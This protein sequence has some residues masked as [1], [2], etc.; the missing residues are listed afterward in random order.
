[1]KVVIAGSR[2]ITSYGQV[3]PVVD[4]AQQ[5]FDFKITEVVSGR[6]V[7]VDRLGEVY[8]IQ[9]GIDIKEFP[10]DWDN[11]GKAAGPERN[12]RMADYADAAVFIWDGKST[13]TLHMIREMKKRR[14]PYYIDLVI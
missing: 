10:A 1:M 7:G 12:C 6:A 11:L 13:G 3:A 9:H 4:Y 14:K 8:A 2:S 5:V